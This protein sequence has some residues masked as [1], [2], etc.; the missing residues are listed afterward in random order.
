MKWNGREYNLELNLQSQFEI[1]DLCPNGD[2]A[3]IGEVFADGNFKKQAMSII[4]IICALSRGYEDHKAY[5]DPAYNPQYLTEE[6]FKFA[7]Q[8]QL[9]TISE[10]IHECLTGDSKQEVETEVKK[11]EKQNLNL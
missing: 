5:E 9:F 4:K 2:F 6:M 10:A 11:T 7:T 8:D 1:A 3:R